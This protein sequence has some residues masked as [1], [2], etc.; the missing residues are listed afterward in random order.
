MNSV[1]DAIATLYRNEH[2]PLTAYV[3]RRLGSE[4]A[5]DVVQESFVNLLRSGDLARLM[6]P[7]SY[8]YRIASNLIVDRC[9]RRRREDD[10]FSD[11]AD[12]DTVTAADHYVVSDAVMRASFL[13]M[14]LREL[15]ETFR[16]VYLMRRV[17]GMT[18]REIADDLDISPRTV[19]R[20]ISRVADK[21]SASRL[22]S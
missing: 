4:E 18:C 11:E 22:H 10:S 7:R 9:R 17:D 5:D 19:N 1:S 15:P 16:T 8:L 20:M 21:L 14:F 13:Q 12:V 2:R 6:Q 3:R